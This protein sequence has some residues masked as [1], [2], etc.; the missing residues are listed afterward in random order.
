MTISMIFFPFSSLHLE[1]LPIT[2][3]GITFLVSLTTASGSCPDCQTAS[4]RVHSRYQ[5]KLK[6]LPSSGLPVQLKLQVRR[7]FCDHPTCS[8]KTFAEAASDLA[9]RYARKTV[10][11]TDVLRQLGFALGGEQ[12]ARIA[13]VLKIACSADT[14][15]R[16]IR[17]TTLTAHPTPTHLGVDDWAFHRNVSYGTILVDLQDHHVVDLLPDRAATTLEAWLIAHPGV[18]LISRDRAGEYATGARKGAPDAIQVADRFH[19]QKNLGEAV[20]KIFH[21]HREALQH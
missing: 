12:G 14:F 7:F 3:A 5:R 13:S 16:L 15:L 9:V 11:L 4:S 1:E 20:E 2:E 6:D 21:R 17:K 18:Q 10:R 8:R 19:I